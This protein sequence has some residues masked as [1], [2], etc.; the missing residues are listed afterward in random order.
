M[1]KAL[2][3]FA[4]LAVVVG[5]CAEAVVGDTDGGTVCGEGFI[6]GSGGACNIP[7]IG[8]A[9]VEA[10]DGAFEAPSINNEALDNQ[11]RFFLA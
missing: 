10:P 7:R 5:G 8:P 1:L 9:D 4:V 6:V 2:V 3:Q 11:R